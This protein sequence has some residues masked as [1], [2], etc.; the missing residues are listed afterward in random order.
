[1]IGL[2]EST[3]PLNLLSIGFL[4]RDLLCEIGQTD[5]ILLGCIG[6]KGE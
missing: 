6:Q 4:L 2:E 5:Q 3:D 1:M